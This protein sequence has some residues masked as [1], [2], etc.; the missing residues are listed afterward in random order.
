MYKYLE[1]ILY[2]LFNKILCFAIT[3]YTKRKKKKTP[4]FDREAGTKNSEK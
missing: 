3:N 4:E 2:N 1:V